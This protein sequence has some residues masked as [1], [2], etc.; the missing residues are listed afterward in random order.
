MAHC[1]IAKHHESGMMFS[2]NFKP[3][4]ATGPPRRTQWRAAA[5]N[6]LTSAQLGGVKSPR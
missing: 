4:M 5:R 1:H 3:E 2:S 6:S